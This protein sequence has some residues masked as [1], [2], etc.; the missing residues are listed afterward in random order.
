[1]FQG[2]IGGTAVQAMDKAVSVYVKG[3]VSV[4][5]TRDLILRAAS[6]KGNSVKSSCCY[7]CAFSQ[8]RETHDPVRQLPLGPNAKVTSMVLQMV[9][10]SEGL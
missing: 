7:P 5:S 2:E 4:F 10:V 9:G 3:I 6:Q 8:N 1:M